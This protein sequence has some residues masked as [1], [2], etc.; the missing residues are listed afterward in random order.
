MLR[1]MHQRDSGWYLAALEQARALG[2]SGG[3]LQAGLPVAESLS[4]EQSGG[5]GSAAQLLVDEHAGT[6][7]DM[8]Q[9]A[10]SGSCC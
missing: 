7:E 8:D 5:G 1:Q 2:T 3:M 6:T 10:V 4:T 9:V